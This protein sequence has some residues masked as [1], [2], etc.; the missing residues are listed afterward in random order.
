M[1]IRTLQRWDYDQVID[2]LQQFAWETGVRELIDNHDLNQVRRM[3]VLCQQGGSS[4]VSEDSGLIT[5]ILLSYR[6]PDVWR[7]SYLRMRELAW[8]VRRDYR[9][10]TIAA[11]L[12]RAYTRSCEELRE[13]GVIRSYTISRLAITPEID[14][15]SRGFQPIET[16]YQR[17]E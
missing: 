17:G 3:L 7:R 14:F 6:E 11:R 16:T 12:F 15:E 1:E 8:F 9:N 13:Q 2:L 10:T 5:G 4:W